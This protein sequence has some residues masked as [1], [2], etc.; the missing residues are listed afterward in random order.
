MINPKGNYDSEYSY[1]R[2]DS[3]RYNGR[4]YISLYDENTNELSDEESRLM[5]T[6]DDELLLQDGELGTIIY[7]TKK[8]FEPGISI[9]TDNIRAFCKGLQFPPEVI[10]AKLTIEGE[11]RLIVNY[12]SPYEVLVDS[13]YSQNFNS[14][15]LDNKWFISLVEAQ[16]LNVE[17][18]VELIKYISNSE[19]NN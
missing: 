18:I 6:N 9:S 15:V 4:T 8:W 3:V 1:S 5:I 19:E 16:Y 13:E 7:Y 12:V 14:E 10:G 11:S 2:L 17:D